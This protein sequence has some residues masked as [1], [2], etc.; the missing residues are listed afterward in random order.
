[1]KVNPD[2][3]AIS[4]RPTSDRRVSF[5]V[6]GALSAALLCTAIGC[7]KSEERV[8]TH[9]VQGTIS[10]QGKPM[11]GAYLVLHSQGA[12]AT[13]PAAPA[14]RASIGA[15]GKFTLTTYD[16]GDGAPEGEYVATVQWYRPIQKNG[17]W[18]SGPNALPRKYSAAGT[19]DIRIRVASGENQLPAIQLR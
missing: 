7:G 9:P 13:E 10:F 2:F 1:M 5:F 4:F 18:V 14:P 3:E 12:S 17:D 15:D 11:P 16:V 6:A 19:S 8:P